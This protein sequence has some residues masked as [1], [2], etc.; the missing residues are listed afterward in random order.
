[1]Y[2]T[3][4][5]ERLS[6][7][8]SDAADNLVFQTITTYLLFF[9]TD[10]YGLR[11]LDITIL[12]IVARVFDI[13]E[14]FL[15]GVAIHKTNTSYGKSRPYFL[16]FSLPYAVFAI[17][18]FTIPSQSYDIKLVW[19][20]L[21]YLG[22]GFLYS[23]V[24]VP[25][26]TI[27]PTMTEDL[28]ERSLLGTI[29]QFFGSL[30]QFV[31][32]VSVLP[33]VS[34]LG[35]GNQ[36]LG[37]NRMIILFSVISFVLIV[38]TFLHVKERMQ[39]ES[40]K[41]RVETTKIFRTLFLDSSW[42]AVSVLIILFWTVMSVKNQSLIYYFKYIWHSES[43]VPIISF[44]TI[45]SVFGVLFSYKISE[46]YSLAKVMKIGVLVAFLGQI[47]LIVGDRES[48]FLISVGT[49]VNSF[50]NGIIVS[51]ISVILAEVFNHVVE[52]YNI[53]AEG[54]IG[55]ADDLGVNIGLGIGGMI[56]TISLY[57]AHYA[58]NEKITQEII[59]AIKWNFVFGP[60]ILYLFLYFT[61]SKYS[62]N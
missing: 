52:K 10:I 18:T 19:A 49:I 21:T 62:K 9:Y 40:I 61:I 26:T 59:N 43:L 23:A 36:Y 32:T 45:T 15:V 35:K 48:L 31:V 53:R 58:T 27:L 30:I 57:F 47:I 16:W 17:L 14:S 28:R 54:I 44:F 33:L 2:V 34:I 60:V 51:L 24:N 39:A 41:K 1:M 29:R 5:K 37:F 38:N 12:F 46:K 25:I 22:L 6:Y 13:F 55:S 11:I 50:G 42:V 7:G 56:T 4:K 3:S 8:L 20:Y